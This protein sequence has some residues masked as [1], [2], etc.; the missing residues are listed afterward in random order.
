MPGL[1]RRLKN[2]VKEARAS[3]RR[4]S[5]ARRLPVRGVSG[6][7]AVVVAPHPDDETFATGGM[8]ALKRARDIPVTVILLTD[9]EA[10]LARFPD[11]SPEAVGRARRGQAA[12]AAGHLGLD[13]ACVIG[14]DLADGKIPRQRQPGFEEAVA[15]LAG[16]LDD[17]GAREVY[18]PH[19]HDGLPDHEAAADI[20]LAAASQLGSPLR[21]VFYVVW[22]WF[23]AQPPL[24]ELFDVEA[25][26]RLDVRPVY[27]QKQAAIA[28]YL[29]GPRAPGGRP[30]CGDL[31]RAVLR[32]AAARSEIFFDQ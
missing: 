28:E 6:D 31:P 14:L 25:G 16:E 17:R 30:Y 11:V 19:P 13:G 5:V 3:W 8:I 10:S 1:I 18:C 29:D 22:A 2:S 12:A 21:V 27:E 23:N 15:R 7:S 26:W 4:A 24:S 20:A 32:S 9:G